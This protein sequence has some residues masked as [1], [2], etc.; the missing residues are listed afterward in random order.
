MKNEKKTHIVR[1]KNGR[2]E[3]RKESGRKEGV[4]RAGRMK[5][6]QEKAR[7]AVGDRQTQVNMD[8]GI[9]KTNKTERNERV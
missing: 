6:R 8:T 2:A 9:K 5:K 7:K 1:Q 3:E 4:R